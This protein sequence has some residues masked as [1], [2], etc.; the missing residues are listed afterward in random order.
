MSILSF[1]S[2]G[3]GG[4]LAKG[5]MDIAKGFFPAK[6]SEADEKQF[7]MQLLSFANNH[8]K[9]MKNLANEEQAEFNRRIA[10]QEGTAK[11][12]KS[13]P[14]VG[15]L[16]IFLRGVQ[17]PAWGF[18]TLLMDYQWFS[19]AWVFNEQQSNAMFLINFLVLGFL[20]G[21]RA[22]QN[23]MPLIIKLMGKP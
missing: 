20:F 11:D 17:R 7:E 14:Y 16:I 5:A 9:E 18:V 22:M 21:E 4:E 10:D 13:I 19:G 2:G 23:L 15:A 12:L 3:I 8:I 1:L 6:L